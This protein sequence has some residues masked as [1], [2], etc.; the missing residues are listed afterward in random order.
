VM[1]KLK[2]FDVVRGKWLSDYVVK[3]EYDALSTEFQ[4]ATEIIKA[5]TKANMTQAELA[6][7]MGTKPTAI[8]RFESP[9]YGKLSISTLKKIAQVLNCD[10]QIRL[11]PRKISRVK[12]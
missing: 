3:K 1:A 5:R 7:K 2:D 9:N 6:G 10:L 8:S 11:R 12:G 4:I